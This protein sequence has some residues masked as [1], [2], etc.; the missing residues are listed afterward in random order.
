MDQ[1]T[2]ELNVM[3]N[4]STYGIKSIEVD[5]SN[6]VLN[7]KSTSKCIIED[8]QNNRIIFNNSEQCQQIIKYFF[9]I[10]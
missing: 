10:S 3:N 6:L 2:N 4:L 7:E 5:T 9:N 8:N 1:V